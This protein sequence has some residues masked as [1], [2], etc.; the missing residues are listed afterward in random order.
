M[1]FI[2]FT[3]QIFSYQLS[4]VPEKLIFS[5][6]R[7]TPGQGKKGISYSGVTDIFADSMNSIMSRDKTLV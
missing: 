2:L 4:G 7:V 5:M 3:F 6:E 1:I